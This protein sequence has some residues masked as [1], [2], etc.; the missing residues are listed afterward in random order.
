MS[1]QEIID[2][3]MLSPLY[4]SL[5]L[6]EKQRVMEVVEGHCQAHHVW[7]DLLPRSDSHKKLYHQLNL[8][9]KRERM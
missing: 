4:S 7:D 3:L 2:I 8:T 9:E 1:R 6:S 5:S